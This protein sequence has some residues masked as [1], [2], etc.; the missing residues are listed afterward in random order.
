MEEEE[1]GK[2]GIFFL[3]LVLLSF[4][5]LLF[6]DALVVETACFLRKAE[7]VYEDEILSQGSL[8]WVEGEERE[9]YHFEQRGFFTFGWLYLQA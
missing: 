4:R 9:K 2:G 8:G 6:F 7:F 5:P 1:G 3:S